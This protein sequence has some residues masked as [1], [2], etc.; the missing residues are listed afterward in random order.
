ML[1]H[2]VQPGRLVGGLFLAATGV[3]F[4]GDA[5]GW[6]ETPWFAVIPLVV[7]GLCLAGVAAAG[8]RS[9]RGRGR[10]GAKTAEGLSPGPDRPR[11]AGSPDGPWQE[12]P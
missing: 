7:G 10:R 6:W 11:A 9:L 12:R 8:A 2:E 5:S 3:I 4:A 1:R